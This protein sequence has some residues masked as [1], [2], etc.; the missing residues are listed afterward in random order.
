GLASLGWASTAK[1]AAPPPG[2]KF[3]LDVVNMAVALPQPDPQDRLRVLT[4]AV[5]VAQPIAPEAAK[6]FAR[7]G[8]HLEAELIAGGQ[9]P[10]VSIF[11][12]GSVD[13][14]SAANFVE[15]LPAAAVERAQDSLLGALSACPKET[16]VP[17]RT[18]LET[19]LA[20]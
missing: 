8:A 10:A 2:K 20:S 3:A 16:L 4:S 7:E 17:A 12:S 5:S 1:N 13:C 11:G 15:S 14:T 6:K 18:K 9:Q 19:A